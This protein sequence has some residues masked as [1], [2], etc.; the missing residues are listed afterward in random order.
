PASAPSWM[1][2][3]THVVFMAADTLSR[4]AVTDGTTADLT[5]AWAW[6]PNAPAERTV[7]WAGRLWDGLS[8]TY[9][10]NMDVV[11]PGDRIVAIEPHRQRD[12]GSP[13]IDASQD[14]VIPGLIESNAHMVNAFGS[15]VGRLWLSYGVTAVYE[16]DADR[17]EAIERRE[18]WA[19]GKRIG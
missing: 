11:V 14:T 2:D 10:Q 3:S 6:K 19:S 7:L 9:R 12:D 18:A 4:T 1:A 13:M 5:P 16:P 17:Q 15:R 8:S